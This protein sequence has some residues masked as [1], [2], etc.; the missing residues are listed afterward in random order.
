MV[1]LLV[2]EPARG[3]T[4]RALRALT[5]RTLLAEV[6]GC[7]VATVRVTRDGDSAGVYGF[8]VDPAPDRRVRSEHLVQR[9]E[10]ALGDVDARVVAHQAQAPHRWGARAQAAADLDPVL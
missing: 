7:A 3:L 10:Q 2:L 9:L 5:E 1:E 6:A 4:P 8:A